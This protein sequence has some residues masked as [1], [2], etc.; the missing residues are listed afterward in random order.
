MVETA[1]E[2]SKDRAGSE[3]TKDPMGVPE[4]DSR[5]GV[6]DPEDITV[7]VGLH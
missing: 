7:F 2:F 5:E 1:G 4:Y 3:S 6:G